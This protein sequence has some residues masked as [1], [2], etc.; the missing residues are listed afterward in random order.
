MNKQWYSI[1]AVLFLSCFAFGQSPTGLLGTGYRTTVHLKWDGYT[2]FQPVGYNIYRSTTSDNYTAPP[3]RIGA[4][5]NY[6]DYDLNASTTFYYK[7]SAID[8]L[9]NQSPLSSQIT[10]STNNLAFTEV[11][12]L[13]LL[14]PIYTG[15]MASDE[16]AQV[17]QALELARLFYYRNS[18][19]KLNLQFH[20]MEITGFPPP[21]GSGVADFA[22]I[23]NDLHNRGILDNQYDA[24]HVVANQIYGWYGG[25]MWLGQTAGS[26]AHTP[27]YSYN[28]N[29]PYT[30]GDFWVFIHEF[31]HSLDM[32]ADQSGH[33]EML[34][35]HYPWAF[36]LPTGINS[37]DIGPDYDGMAAVLRIFENHLNY[38]APWDGYIEVL[39]TDADG[40]ANTDSRLPMNEAA[41]LSNPNTADS[42]GDGLND[43]EEFYAGN[44]SSANPLLS[45]TDSDGE[46][47]GSD[48]YPTSN[49]RPNVQKTNAPI[50]INGAMALGEGWQPLVSN[51]YFSL[52]PGASFSASATWDDNYLYFAF[53]G[54]Q[55][56]KYYLYMDGSGED[57]LFSSPIRF[58]NGNYNDINDAA[59]GDSYYE[60]AV[61][62]IR[63]DASQVVLKNVAVAGSQVA[64]S[65][66]G[67]IYTTEVRLPHN[68]G[69]GFG[70][71]YTPPSA[72]VVNTQSYTAGDIIG[73]NLIALP[74]SGANGNETDEWRSGNFISM[75]EVLHYYDMT[76]TSSVPTT[77]CASTSNFPWEDWVAK[78]KIGTINNASGK[79]PYSDFTNIST[80]L[81]TGSTPVEL[82]TGFSYFTWDEYWRVWIDLN[83][84]GDFNDAGETVFEGIKAK[85]ANGTPTAMLVGNIN[86][87]TS[88]LTGVT[89]MRISMKR[90]AFAMPCETLP[91][92]EV[93]DYSVNI[94]G[95]P[96]PLP[97]L[98]SV[99]WEIIPNTNTY[100]FTAPG[101][102]YGY[103]GGLVRNPAQVAVTTPFTTKVWLSKDNNIGAGDVLWQTLSYTGIGADAVAGLYIN[104]PVPQNTPPGI[105][106]ILVKVDADNTVSESDETNNNYVIN[107]QKIGAPDFALQNL[108]GVPASVAVNGNLNFSVQVKD[109]ANFPLNELND[110]MGVI[111]VLSQDALYGGFDDI[112]LG[113]ETVGMGQFIAGTATL[114]LSRT[115]PTTVVPGTYY[116]ILRASAICEAN[117]QNNEI[118]SAVITVT[119]GGGIPGHY[120]TPYSNFPWEDWIAGIRIGTQEKTSSK[121]PYSDFSQTFNFNLS[122]GSNAVKLTGGFSY[123]G[124]EAYWRIWIDFNRDG[125]FVDA[126]ELVLSTIMPKGPDGAPTQSINTSFNIPMVTLPGATRMRVIMKRGAFAS[127]CENIAFGE[128]EDYSV[129]IAAQG[130]CKKDI[131]GSILCHEK[132]PT[133]GQYYVY[134]ENQGALAR[135]TLNKDGEI[136]GQTPM[137]AMTEDSTLVQ[138]N[139]VVRKL[140]NGSVA[141][142]KPIT[143]SVLNQFPN[144]EA[145]VE[146]NDGTFI[147]GGFQRQYNQGFIVADSL[148]LIK[149]DNN[150][151]YLSYVRVSQFNNNLNYDKLKGF[152]K[153][154]NGDI[155]V[156]FQSANTYFNTI[157]GYSFIKYTPQLQLVASGGFQYTELLHWRPTPCGY[158]SIGYKFSFPSIKSSSAGTTTILYD[159]ETMS[160]K[161][162]RTSET[163]IVSYMGS[164]YRESYSSNLFGDTL[165]ANYQIVISQQY[166]SPFTISLEK[167]DGT[168]FQ[169]RPTLIDFNHILQTG[170]TTVLFLGPNW[171]LNPDCGSPGTKQPD[172]SMANLTLQNANTT[173]GA[174]VWFNFDL[175]NTGNATATGEYIIAAYLSNDSQLSYEDRL[176][177]YIN[178]G[179]TPV[180][181]IP[182]VL[183]GITVPAEQP[184]GQYYLI[185]KADVTGAIV[186]LNENN[187]VLSTSVKITVSGAPDELCGFETTVSQDGF[188]TYGA[189]SINGHHVFRMSKYDATAN[190][191]TF[192]NYT[193]GSDGTLTSTATFSLDEKAT[194]LSDENFLSATIGEPN[195]I[196]LKK[197]NK[198]GTVLWVK[199]YS[200]FIATNI[201]SLSIGET[202]NGDILLAGTY[203]ESGYPADTRRV[204]YMRLDYNGKTLQ[205]NYFDVGNA[206][207]GTTAS[208]FQ[209]YNQNTYLVVEVPI[210]GFTH[211]AFL[212]KINWQYGGVQWQKDLGTFTKI[213]GLA[214]MPDGSTLVTAF[215]PGPPG[216]SPNSHGIFYR[217]D[218]NGNVL[219]NKDMATLAPP[220]PASATT[221]SFSDVSPIMR[222]TD[223]GFITGFTRYFPYSNLPSQ[224]LIIRL[225]NNLDTVWTKTIAG[226]DA[227][228]FKAFRAVPGGA[229]LGA[230][231]GK[232]IKIGA[233]GQFTPCTSPGSYC[234][235]SSNFPWED[236]ISKVKLGSLDNT[237]GKSPYSDFTALSTSLQKGA[238]YTMQLTT[239]FSYFTWDEYWTVWIDLNHDNIFQN[240]SEAVLTKMLTAPANG[241]ATATISG[242]FKLPSNALN[243]PTRMRVTMKRGG[244]AMP[245]ETL[246]FG[247]IEDYTVNIVDML[248]GDDTDNRAA[249]LSFEAVP[250]KTWVV[251]SGAYAFEEPVAQVEV[252]KSTDGMAYGLLET[253]N[254]KAVPGNAQALQVTDHQPNDGFNYYRMLLLL[255]NG[256]EFYSPVRVVSYHAPLD[257][258][259]FPNPAKNEVFVQLMEAPKA[260]MQWSITDAYGRVVWM[261]KIAPDAPFPYRIDVTG[262]RDGLYYLFA[263]QPGRKAVGKRFVVIR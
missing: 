247:E 72:A 41:F 179:N 239:S 65:F 198:L 190:V 48:P 237:S 10:V 135:Y 52:Q 137:P 122:Q 25:A 28:A 102:T 113:S 83:H 208:V 13:E 40:L 132:A 192:R 225:N 155:V 114:N 168:I 261:Q 165:S 100:C 67:G 160:T 249:N 204:W 51:P 71:T 167:A 35:N 12:N 240:P 156:V 213:R 124:Y 251:L 171:A 163:G 53:Q 84:D 49:F 73:V 193:I 4:Y 182:S 229:F 42:D 123:F 46:P 66:S 125:D 136:L 95:A 8:A 92:G 62:I 133:A 90:G 27:G 58:A 115:L 127:P 56:M 180:G 43:L 85:P 195:I 144:I 16:P 29:N 219:F 121:S 82:S 250:E 11:A 216:G 117:N 80:N 252:E 236:W 105:Y 253:I 248:T 145:A 126:G 212:V 150:L 20:F 87:P 174:V 77:Y 262:L 185:L 33:P 26:M 129:N 63:S 176:T 140:A 218:E 263:Q 242:T 74:L 61:I 220:I 2:A 191:S 39:D 231:D 183:G 78:V 222:G 245:C 54:N 148:V 154:S 89:R 68:L 97:D 224:S 109:L 7:I 86:I 149:T 257:Y 18:K 143:A 1:Y 5:T 215:D 59:Y 260:E 209:G 128:I 202:I 75:N 141:W 96:L 93:E 197:V 241:T 106:N 235:S 158:Y 238:D 103:L 60:S 234:N 17:R 226:V 152:L 101:S 99:A 131:P 227:T 38:A 169:K 55:P 110:N 243:G 200:I 112:D 244:S 259:L 206:K 120:C 211:T 177:G 151:N 184:N 153:T 94:A 246:A 187:N 205:Q 69:P 107:N 146:L 164:Y 134:A 199:Q 118:M 170:D 203:H 3:K 228:L 161:T 104:E 30:T 233:N 256:D 88:A 31:G 32:L 76:L 232:L 162:S 98:T 166:I 186:E 230:K 214:E 157:F 178:T 19:A 142:Q 175:K 79:S 196:Y 34:F 147:L 221:G 181:T 116:L 37:F 210:Y 194:P 14:I 108:I 70:W 6:T 172:I 91:F 23:A 9:G 57:G 173:P 255:E 111:A 130:A 22:T 201:E 207:T 21:N 36:P 139:M 138:N 50:N 223:G 258:T 47:D 254:G 217:I 64:T 188:T 81:N 189:A 45:D 119:A 159:F 44:L 24:I 15:G